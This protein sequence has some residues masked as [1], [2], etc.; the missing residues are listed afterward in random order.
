MANAVRGLMLRASA[1]PAVPEGAAPF[2]DPAPAWGGRKQGEK[3]Q[4]GW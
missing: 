4:L 3:G 1:I 2:C